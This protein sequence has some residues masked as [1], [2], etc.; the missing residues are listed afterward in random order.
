MPK[1]YLLLPDREI[2]IKR[3]CSFCN[4]EKLYQEHADGGVCAFGVFAC[5]DCL[6][7]DTTKEFRGITGGE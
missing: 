3:R 4:L 1:S 7:K 2:Q 5:A 6:G